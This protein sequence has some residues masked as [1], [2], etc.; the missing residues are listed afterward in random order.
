[1]PFFQKISNINSGMKIFVNICIS[2]YF[3][4]EYLNDSFGSMIFK[5]F[6]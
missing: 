1:M 4:F 6:S 3:S 2:K 5:G